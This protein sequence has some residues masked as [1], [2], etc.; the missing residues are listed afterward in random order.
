MSETSLLTR[1]PHCQ[2]RF[3]VTEEQLTVANGKVRCGNCMQVFHALEQQELPSSG[4][5]KSAAASSSTEDQSWVPEDNDFHDPTGLH[6]DEFLFSDELQDEQASRAVGADDSDP[7]ADE[8]SDSFRELGGGSRRGRKEVEPDFS[9][10]DESWAEAMLD[11]D[12]D[13][14]LFLDERSATGQSSTQTATSRPDPRPLSPEELDDEQDDESETASE[15]AA[16]RSTDPD[17]VVSAPVH[18]APNWRETPKEDLLA[19]LEGLG[20]DERIAPSATRHARTG[21]NPYSDLKYEPQPAPQTHSR[22]RGRGAILWTLLSLALIGVLVSQVVWFQF[23]RLSQI[24]ELRPAYEKACE[25]A[26]CELKPLVAVDA[27][28]ARQL[29]VR[30][31]PGDPR[32]L[33]VDAQM[34][35]QASF[36]Q[37]YPVLA[38]TF[39]NLEGDVVAQSLFRPSQY[40]PEQVRDQEEM[41]VNTPVNIAIRIK[42]PGKD[43]VNYNLSFRPADR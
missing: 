2:T 1:C 22:K 17:Y 12:D 30:P 36:A 43:A 33:M 42:D 20:A 11:D 16:K 13:S 26:G 4:P 23:D 28:V 19:A 31:A 8:L 40:L 3:R 7:F 39:S 6:D 18:R 5:G 27:I 38:L 25:Y 15:D 10:E 14:P 24:P 21:S 32:T 9:V 37:P 41:A 29:E 34:I 35:N